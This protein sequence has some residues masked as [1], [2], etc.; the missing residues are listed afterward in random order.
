MCGDR[1]KI[2]DR[3]GIGGEAGGE[4]GHSKHL[5]RRHAADIEQALA[6]QAAH[7]HQLF[8]ITVPILEADQVGMTIGQPGHGFGGI[9]AVVAVVENDGQWADG[10]ADGVDVRA[11][12][13]LCSTLRR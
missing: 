8:D 6:Q 10:A 1:N 4:V 12:K 9:E 5:S 11:S 3:R 7:A 13:P 2:V